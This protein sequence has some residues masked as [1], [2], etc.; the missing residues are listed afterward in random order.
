M[1]NKKIENL[2]CATECKQHTYSYSI[3]QSLAQIRLEISQSNRIQLSKY[4]YIYH[5]RIVKLIAETPII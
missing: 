2:V 4:I 1:K 3:C 5:A